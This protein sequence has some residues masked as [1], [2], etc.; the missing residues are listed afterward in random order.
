MASLELIWMLLKESKRSGSRITA[1]FPDGE[2]FVFNVID[3]QDC[4]GKPTY[5]IAPD[6]PLGRALSEARLNIEVKD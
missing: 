6:L 1:R 5:T 3:F 2:S 4:D